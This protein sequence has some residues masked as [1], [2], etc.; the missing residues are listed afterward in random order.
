MLTTTIMMMFSVHDDDN[1]KVS[2]S[3]W[4]VLTLLAM[5]LLI[6]HHEGDDED[7]CDFDDDEY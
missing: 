1:D 4:S 3:K 5:R 7:E 6:V 2:L